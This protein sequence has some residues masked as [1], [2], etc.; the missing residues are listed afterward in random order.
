MHYLV[1]KYNMRKILIALCAFISLSVNAKKTIIIQKPAIIYNTEDGRIYINKVEYTDTATILS[2]TYKNIFSE[3]INVNPYIHLFDENGA[4]HNLRHAIG[5]Q[6]GKNTRIPSSGQIDYKLIFDPLPQNTSYFDLVEQQGGCNVY[7]IHDAKMKLNIPTLVQHKQSIHDWNKFLSPQKAVLKG[8][9]EGNKGATFSIS[10][11]DNLTGTEMTQYIKPDSTGAFCQV[12]DIDYP[13]IIIFNKDFRSYVASLIPGDTCSINFTKWGDITYNDATPYSHLMNMYTWTKSYNTALRDKQIEYLA[14][15]YHLT[16]KEIMLAI[17]NNDLNIYRKDAKQYCNLDMNLM[18]ISCPAFPSFVE[19]Y[20]ESLPNDNTQSEENQTYPLKNFDDSR[21]ASDRAIFGKTSPYL[22]AGCFINKYLDAVYD[23]NTDAFKKMITYRES[24]MTDKTFATYYDKTIN[25]MEMEKSDSTLFERC[26]AKTIHCK[27]PQEYTIKHLPNGMEYIIVRDTMPKKT[28]SFYLIQKTGTNDEKDN[29]RGFAHFVEH[30][31][32]R[33]SKHFADQQIIH[34]L[35]SIGLNFGNDLN[36]FTYNFHTTYNIPGVKINSESRIDSCLLILGDIAHDL[37]IADT[38]VISERMPISDEIRDN[39]SDEAL[40]YYKVRQQHLAGTPYANLQVVS[41]NNIQHTTGKELRE[42]YHKWYQPQNQQLVIFGDIDE[43]NIEEKVKHL[44]TNIPRG[45]T[46]KNNCENV[47]AHKGAKV[48]INTDNNIKQTCIKLSFALPNIDKKLKESLAYGG[49][50]YL[51]NSLKSELQNRLETAFNQNPYIFIN[52][53]PLIE[54]SDTYFDTKMGRCMQISFNTLPNK[55]KEALKLIGKAV[56]LTQ[57]NGITK[58]LYLPKSKIDKEKL[59]NDTTIRN[60]QDPSFDSTESGNM[61]VNNY[62]EFGSNDIYYAL[63]IDYYWKQRV[64]QKDYKKYFKEALNSDHLTIFYHT[65]NQNDVPENN[66]LINTYDKCISL[67]ELLNIKNENHVVYKNNVNPKPGK[68][69]KQTKIGNGITLLELSNGVK[70]VINNTNDSKDPFNYSIQAFRPGGY[71]NYSVADRLQIQAIPQAIMHFGHYD[72]DQFQHEIKFANYDIDPSLNGDEIGVKFNNS[73]LKG[74]L[75]NGMNDGISNLSCFYQRLT[76]TV[77]NRDKFDTFVYKTKMNEPDL[78][79]RLSDLMQTNLYVKSGRR[80]EIS[81]ENV[82]RLNFDRIVKLN[83]LYHANYNGMI[84]LLKGNVDINKNMPDILKY[85]GGL[86]SL[87]K[88][89]QTIE[90]TDRKFKAKG[91]LMVK[92]IENNVPWNGTIIS[93]VRD[94]NVKYDSTYYKNSLLLKKILI[95]KLTQQLRI[96]KHKIYSI[97]VLL[98]PEYFIS[99]S[100]IYNIYFVSLPKDRQEII[101]IINA[102]LKEIKNGKGIS[103]QE[104]DILMSNAKNEED[105]RTNNKN[106]NISLEDI[107]QFFFNHGMIAEKSDDITNIS[108]ND[109]KKFAQ[110]EITKSR[111]FETTLTTK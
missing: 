110:N 95:L 85:L 92:E 64:E 41:L 45:N 84:V 99:T 91:S 79:A 36:A 24:K 13:Q 76:P 72:G 87:K 93:L 27:Y 4:W 56:K 65:P 62:K 30:M 100:M 89:M 49:I 42:Y 43:K 53:K 82:D 108:F 19:T 77:T 109:F 12:I 105:D 59:I 21:F 96:D 102:T 101:N 46:I 10:W 40:Y 81:S 111:I 74:S 86:P 61:Y 63:M 90:T 104:F 83:K 14:N 68:L 6:P 78:Y 69:V 28:A 34:Y 70:V 55:W 18:G 60:I 103:K 31:A 88:P 106:E 32:F 26:I 51:N 94:K 5:I 20:F 71:S 66:Q 97:N 33:G 38:A 29:E 75:I 98:Q 9:L 15:R 8:K 35:Q 48:I 58:S 16:D 11:N 73:F 23:E 22:L 3:E 67:A 7:G 54:Y 50:E 107:K 17:I 2:I 39:M 52:T 57:L 44:F 1:K 25:K 80:H 37:T 47:P